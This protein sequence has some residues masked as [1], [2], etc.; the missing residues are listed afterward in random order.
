[1]TASDGIT[2]IHIVLVEDNEADIEL[3]RIA[4]ERGRIMNR[5][6]VLSHGREALEWFQ[7]LSRGEHSDRPDLVLLDLNLPGV[8]GDE[9]LREMKGDAALVMIPVV[10]LTT[11]EDDADVAAAYR[12]H[13][14]AFM[15]KP[16]D[17]D[18]FLKLVRGITDYWF[19]L[20]R[21]PAEGGAGK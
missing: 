6:T 1:M 9:I 4:F 5:M 16:V 8:N 2:P 15:T 17:Y 11:S 19:T 7:A 12:E 20:V 3:T 14:N 13:A 18:R 21:L 10:V